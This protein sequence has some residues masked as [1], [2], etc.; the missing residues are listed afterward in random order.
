[1]P[2]STIVLGEDQ[3]FRIT[4][5]SALSRIADLT[6]LACSHPPLD[7]LMRALVTQTLK[8]FGVRGSAILLRNNNDQLAIQSEYGLRSDQS[9]ALNE[10]S[11]DS[12]HP[13]ALAMQTTNHVYLETV[14]D[15]D[16]IF[17]AEE[18]VLLI[19]IVHK[20]E[21]FGV[22]LLVFQKQ[23]EMC[24]LHKSFFSIISN[25]LTQSSIC[26]LE[27]SS[28]N[29]AITNRTSGKSENHASTQTFN[30]DAELFLSD[31][32]LTPRQHTIA[33]KIAN[34]VT[35]REIAREMGYSEATIRYETIKLYE[36]LRVRNRS[37]A[38][39]RIRELKIT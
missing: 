12:S 33:I 21:I 31:L 7:G 13:I 2:D 24:D 14:G 32:G 11:L 29:W 23:N 39:A 15:L 17:G 30:Q 10:F 6:R 28:E 16:A 5:E 4:H 22:F 35:N 9:S 27:K 8:P 1:M 19:P 18:S 37:H 36:R 25:V 20:E 26:Q 3:G 38:A 34:G